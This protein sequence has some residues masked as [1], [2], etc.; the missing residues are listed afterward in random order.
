MEINII[1][2]IWLLVERP[3]CLMKYQ[4]HILTLIP[5]TSNKCII[6][7]YPTMSFQ[8]ILM[9]AKR[10]ALNL[11]ILRNNLGARVHVLVF[12]AISF[13]S[14]SRSFGLCLTRS[15]STFLLFW[16]CTQTNVC[17]CSTLSTHSPSYHPS[18]PPWPWDR[19]KII[20]IT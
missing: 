16:K 5:T 20:R 13:H 3:L 17:V 15:V 18:N 2:T 14:C 8:L 1:N 9:S 12:V 7:T 10:N 19:Q 4:F 11:T 6:C